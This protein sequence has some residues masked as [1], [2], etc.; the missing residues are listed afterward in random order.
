MLCEKKA[1][2]SLSL[3]GFNFFYYLAES[4]SEKDEENPVFCLAPR[5]SKMDLSYT[6]GSFRLE[7]ARKRSHLAI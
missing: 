6:L 4:T 1:V 5:A 3:L 7:P 2:Y